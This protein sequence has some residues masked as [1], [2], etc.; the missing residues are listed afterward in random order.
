MAALAAAAAVAW[1]APAS[2]T[3]Y[4]VP[5][6]GAGCDVA[7]ATVQ[8]AFIA[9][10]AS[11]ADDRVVIAPGT[12]SGPFTYDATGVDA[13]GLEVVGAGAF[14]TTLTAAPAPNV[15]VLVLNADASAEVPRVHDLGVLVRNEPGGF[16]TAIR[17]RAVLERVRVSHLPDTPG[18]GGTTGVALRGDGAALRNAEVAVDGPFGVGVAGDGGTTGEPVVSDSRVAASFAA[19]AEGGPL[20][21]VRSRLDGVRSGVQACNGPARVESTLI[22]IASPAG[23][24]LE[25]QG[26]NRCGTTP[27]PIDARHVT[28]VGPGTATPG[29]GVSA[30]AG[31][32]AAT[33]EL[34]H[35]IVRDFQTSLD[36]ETQAPTLT[37]TV[38]VSASDFE[39][40]RVSLSGTGTETLEEPQSNIDA[41]PLF[42]NAAAGDFSLSAGS[43]A[44]EAAFSDPL[45]IDESPTDLLGAPRIADANGD[46]VARRDMGAFE[47]AGVAPAAASPPPGAAAPIVR[48]RLSLRGSRIVVGKGKRARLRLTLTRDARVTATVLKGKKVVRRTAKRL[49]AGRRVLALGRPLPQGSYRLVIVA[50]AGGQI[51]RDTARLIV[52]G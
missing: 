48:L 38:R 1:P 37:A 7:S 20:K 13:G 18:G 35:S 44:L 21:I 17:A 8:A 14:A 49:D 10:R 9:A 23:L 32:V 39:R 42:A 50:R 25:A 24:G 34:R 41:D 2:A 52:R 46:G 28:I 31:L 15:V 12:L 6:A 5:T 51:S 33:V 11:P 27:S 36:L 47:R 40:A 16:A 29:S 30:R 43:P 3:T 22:R 45:A 4:C 26:D 19:I